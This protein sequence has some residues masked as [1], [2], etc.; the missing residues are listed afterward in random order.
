MFFKGLPNGIILYFDGHEYCDILLRTISD[1]KE[2]RYLIINKDAKIV[3]DEENNKPNQKFYELYEVKQDFNYKFSTVTNDLNNKNSNFGIFNSRG[4]KTYL[5]YAPI[6]DGYV[7]SEEPLYLAYFLDFDEA[8]QNANYVQAKTTLTLILIMICV[9]LFVIFNVAYTITMLA[10]DRKEHDFSLSK[11]NYFRMKVQTIIIDKK[12]KIKKFNRAF[13]RELDNPKDYKNVSDFRLYEEDLEIM[14]VISQQ[15]PFTAIFL[16]PEKYDIYIHFLPVLVGNRYYLLGENATDSV[17]ESIKNQRFAM[18]N[19]ITNLPNRVL[20]DKSCNELLSV[21]LH[22]IVNAVV[23]VDILD[24][25]KINKL[26][27]FDAANNLLREMAKAIKEEAKN[28]NFEL[29]NIRTSLFLIIFRNLESFNQIVNWSKTLYD[30]LSQ[31]LVIKDGY[32]TSVEPRVGILNIDQDKE[33]CATFAKVYDSVMI[34]LDRAKNSK[35]TF[36]SIY[37]SEFAQMVSR[38]QMMEDDLRKGLIN[39]EFNMYF[40]PQYNTKYKRIEGFE[41][42]IRWDNPKYAKENVEHFIRIAEKNGSIVQIGDIIINQTFAF[43]KTIED[44][45]IHIS[46]NVSP[47]Q[48]LQAGFV[49]EIIARFEKAQLKRGSIAIEITETFMMENSANMIQK[50]K[51]LREHGFSIHLDDFGMGY[52]S[53]LY[54]KD[55]PVDAIKIDKEFT[56]F[57]INDKFS[58]VIIAKIVQIANNLELDIIAEGVET[59]KQ[60]DMLSKMGAYV[61]QGFLISKPVNK[62]ETLELI[63]KYN[64]NSKVKAE[65]KKQYTDEEVYKDVKIDFGD[66]DSKKKKKGDDE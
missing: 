1:I 49:N 62:E 14:K 42:L 47:V 35:I 61:I 44:T 24:F 57:M 23:A 43:A 11:I 3:L 46:M 63:K 8:N 18:Y 53:L 19:S 59:E 41:A 37:S 34:A 28:Y 25:A 33:E 51:L 12:G 22:G 10:Y 56:R 21:D 60:S 48:L 65:V 16:S 9:I 2:S 55:L 29:F 15:K 36:T 54:L 7:D 32:L 39:N 31:P 45:G 52:S 20:F 64:G 26:F 40:Q 27:G 17:L 66:E 6:L 30:R 38:D 13:Q 5:V 50:L 58:R 4:T